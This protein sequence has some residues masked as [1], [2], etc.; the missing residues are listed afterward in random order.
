MILRQRMQC[1]DFKT[2]N[3]ML[4][5]AE[6][7]LEYL[8]KKKDPSSTVKTSKHVAISFA[9]DVYYSENVLTKNNE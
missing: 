4:D 2:A 9:L 7:K 1:Y 3:A 6:L 5:D 8:R